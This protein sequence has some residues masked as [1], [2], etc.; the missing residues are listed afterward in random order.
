MRD[1]AKKIFVFAFIAFICST[2]AMLVLVSTPRAGIADEGSRATIAAMPVSVETFTPGPH[3]ARVRALG[4]AVPIWNTTLRSL[5]DGR[6]VFLSASLQPGVT[7]EKGEVLVRL[8]QSGHRMLVAEARSRLAAAK[9]VLLAEEREA[10]EAEKNWHRS[11]LTGEPASP[12]VLRGPQLEAARAE[13]E[14]AEAA[15]GH[16]NMQLH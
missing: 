9:I 14:A 13:I 12:L 6:I 5:V 15:L 8:E 11:G 7:V 10:R 4:E 3:A 2:V 16:A 1:R